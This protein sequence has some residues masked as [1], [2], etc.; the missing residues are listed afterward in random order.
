MLVGLGDL[1]SVVL[2]FLAREDGLGRIVV[3]SRNVERTTA[4]C[5]LARL[6]AIAQGCAP[7]IS[8]VPLDLE[9]LE[10]VAETVHREAPDVIV[11]TATMQTWWLPS[12]LPPEQR[13]AIYSAGFGVWLPVHMTLTLKL[14][15]ALREA[16]YTG[17]TLTAPFP[18]VVNCVLG[19]LDLAPTCGLGNVAQFVPKV[20]LLA[21]GRLGAPLDAVRVL[22][23]AHH[24]LG[25]AVVRSKVDRMP[26][27]FLRIEHGGQDV[28]EAIGADELLVAPYRRTAGPASHFLTAG[29]TVRLIRALLSDSGAL[30]HEPAPH[31]LPGGYPVV[32]GNGSVQPAPI[33]GLTLEEA[34]DINERSHRFDGIERIEPDGT[35]VFCP[36]AVDALRVELGYDCQRLPPEE[37]EERAKELIARFREYAARYGV[38]IDDAE[39]MTR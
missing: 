5:N 32:V 16:G 29:T 34:I 27:Y 22:M 30:L 18:D 38:K 12:L 6:G 1:G 4:R 24:A 25:P 37:S 26:P 36:E 8:F 35:V 23:V 39:K 11:S 31:G 13:A 9:D 2:E 15:Q 28:T 17:A 33:D 19:R 3:A 20:R 14:M 7:A 10:A 21:A